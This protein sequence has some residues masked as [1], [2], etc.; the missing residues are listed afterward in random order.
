MFARILLGLFSNVA[1]TSEVECCLIVVVIRILALLPVRKIFQVDI[2]PA[3]GRHLPVVQP[4]G[5]AYR[6]VLHG[7]LRVDILELCV[8]D[9]F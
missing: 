4:F 3:W 2:F 7:G 5:G 9:L 1:L 6:F 8:F